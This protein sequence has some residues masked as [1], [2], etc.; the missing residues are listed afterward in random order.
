MFV[1]C[2]MY[3]SVHKVFFGCSTNN[4]LLNQRMIMSKEF[5]FLVTLERDP[6]FKN[7]LITLQ[8]QWHFFYELGHREVLRYFLSNPSLD[9]Q[10][11]AFAK[12]L[13]KYNSVDLG[14]VC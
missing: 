12:V 4:E 8:F 5:E 13:S 6:F 11:Q 14:N 10:T 9:N 3:L 1:N 2:K 7:T